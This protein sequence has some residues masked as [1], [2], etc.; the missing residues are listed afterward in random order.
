M[1]TRNINS[2]LEETL[3]HMIKSQVY[4]Y[5][6]EG[7]Q[8]LCKA[9]FLTYDF[10]AVKGARMCDKSANFSHCGTCTVMHDLLFHCAK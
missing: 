7:Y 5:D 6:E 4:K 1:D 10:C 2:T 3:K 8:D 9:Q